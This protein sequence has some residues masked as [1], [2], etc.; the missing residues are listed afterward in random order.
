MAHNA[1]LDRINI[2]YRCGGAE[3]CEG[4]GS[5]K[6]PFTPCIHSTMILLDDEGKSVRYCL[7]PPLFPCPTSPYTKQDDLPLWAIHRDFD[8]LLDQVKWHVGEYGV[9]GEER[10]NIIAL[11]DEAGRRAKDMAKEVVE[12]RGNIEKNKV[13][14]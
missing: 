4:W 6:N 13:W 1:T 12:G 11:L 10:N 8:V 2:R 3:G 5:P 14:K 9:E 7:K